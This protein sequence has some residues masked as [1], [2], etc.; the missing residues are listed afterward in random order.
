[1]DGSLDSSHCLSST[2]LQILAICG[3]SLTIPFGGD[4]EI[5][6]HSLNPIQAWLSLKVLFNILHFILVITDNNNQGIGIS[7]F[8]ITLFPY[9]SSE[10]N[11]Q[12]LDLS[13]L[14]SFDNFYLR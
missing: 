1:M 7:L 10:P 4:P 11:H 3:L 8:L 5:A 6:Q 9:G 2:V 13:F 14:S 12:E